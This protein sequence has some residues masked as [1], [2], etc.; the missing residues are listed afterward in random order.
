MAQIVL[1]MFPNTVWRSEPPVVQYVPSTSSALHC[2]NKILNL[3]DLLDTVFYVGLKNQWNMFS[4]T[5]V[6]S[7]N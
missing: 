1:R 5:S 3:R 7:A 6:V 4:N 2:Y